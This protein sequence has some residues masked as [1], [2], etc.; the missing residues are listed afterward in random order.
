MNAVAEFAWKSTVVLAAAFAVNYAMRRGSAA[1]RHFVWTAALAV[2][3]PMAV[4]IGI[5]PRWIAA[6]APA[7]TAA[8]TVHAVAAAPQGPAAPRVSFEWIYLAGAALVLARFAIGIGRTGM[9]AR[10]ARRAEHAIPMVEELRTVLRITRPVRALEGADIAVPMAWGLLRP[11]ALLP[12]SSRDWPEGRLRTVLLHELTHVK[13][14][15]LLAQTL[16]QAVCCLFW[17]HP[18]VWLATRELRKERERACDDAVLNRGVPPAEYAG[19]LMELARSLA[20]RRAAIADAPAMAETSDLELR[21][22]AL[23]DRGCNRTPLT[24]RLALTVTALTCALVLPVATLTTYAQAGRGALAGI[25]TDPSGANIPRGSVI[26]KNLDGTNIET[27]KVDLTGEYAFPSIPPGRYEIEARVP[28]FMILKTPAVVTAGT[29]TRAD[30][31]MTLGGVSEVVT[32]RGSRTTPAP[33]QA[34]TRAPQR[35]PIGGSVQPA[36]LLRQARPV[37]PQELKDQGIAAT[38]TIK[39]IISKTGDILNPVVVNTVDPAFAKAAL[40]AVKQWQYTP[41][42]LNGEPVEVV[43]TIDVLFELEQ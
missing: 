40:D 3:L 31:R 35:I 20:A 24:R 18:L 22:R 19:H 36:R 23:L 17:F 29:A 34:P 30:L 8:T 33:M 43:T 39:A 21:V 12:E 9:I 10:K 6:P 37:Y 5:G 38:V 11:L 32:V 27:A 41:T 25:V 4:M 13:R 28:G 26:A 14:H 7:A 42:L 15:D 1:V 2:L 16:A